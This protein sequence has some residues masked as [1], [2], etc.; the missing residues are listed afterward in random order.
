MKIKSY[1]KD[2]RNPI[3]LLDLFKYKKPNKNLNKIYFTFTLDLEKDFNSK[4]DDRNLN[5]ILNFLEDYGKGTFF[6]ETSLLNDYSF[7]LDKNEVAS[8]GYGHLSF[9]DEW[10]VPSSEKSKDMMGNIKKS[11][12]LIKDN[13]GIKPISFRAPRFSVS[14]SLNNILLK[15]GY[16]VNSS[17]NPHNNVF[18]PSMKDGI[19][20]V[21]LSRYY[22]PFLDFRKGF[23]YLKY[24][25]LMF[26][27][28][29]LEGF[30]KFHILSKKILQS[31][32]N[33]SK[34][35][36]NFMCHNWDFKS[37]RDF[38]LMRLYLDNLQKE[39]KVKFIPLKKYR[40]IK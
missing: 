2:R 26:S 18:L 21:P 1:L 29:K 22:K 23:P 9:G 31:W 4:F 33:K 12:N 16:T 30:D 37:E 11:T 38:D 3:Y 14:K 34:P 40:V 36:L 6:V 10:W 8:H 28:L 7:S 19:L 17:N 20:D 15:N 13:F 35:I 27:N 24:N 25:S 32:S 39:F 5:K